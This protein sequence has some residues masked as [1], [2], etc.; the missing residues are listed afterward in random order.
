MKYCIDRFESG[1]A[2]CES[3]LREKC[4]FPR[5]SLY[6]GAKEGDWFE[7]SKDEICFLSELTTQKRKNNIER[8][9]KLM[10]N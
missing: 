5:E 9:K 6:E 1:I 4:E 2:V 8:L 3:E 10:G 7:K